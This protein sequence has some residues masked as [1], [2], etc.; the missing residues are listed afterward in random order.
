MRRR[1]MRILCLILALLTP[2]LPCRA[3]AQVTD[4]SALFINVG[5]ADSALLFIGEHTY[6]IDTGTDFRAAAMINAIKAQNVST[7]DAVFITHAHDDHA[8]GLAALLADGDISVKALYAPE[9]HG[10]KSLE[11]HPVYTASR[12]FGVPLTWL[13]SGDVLP[14]G[15]NALMTVLGPVT[16]DPDNENNNSL[17]CLVDTAQGSILFTGDMELGEEAELLTLGLIPRATVLKVAHHGKDDANGQDMIMAV[18]PQ[19][20]VISTSTYEDVDTPDGKVLKRLFAVNASAHVT[21]DASCGVRIALN[22]GTAKA[23][24][25]NYTDIPQIESALSFALPDVE[26]DTVTLVNSGDADISLDGYTLY[27]ERGEQ[28]YRLPYGI[29]V[30]AGGGV[31]IG[32]QNSTADIDITWPVKRLWNLKNPD[33]V[34]L[35]DIYGRRV[36]WLAKP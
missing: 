7:L 28:T 2:L 24:L 1:F 25:E 21:Q 5:K 9:L 22:G 27:S 14:L 20:G 3:L 10:K 13:R 35:Y 12:D 6:L 32:G 26:N 30:P 15:D 34:E 16:M 31:V 18:S 33:T 8:G 19:L 36:A 17:V 11:K 4:V 29:T 23:Y